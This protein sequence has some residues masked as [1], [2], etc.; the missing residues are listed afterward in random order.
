MQTKIM[1]GSKQIK[2]NSPLAYEENIKS[3]KLSI[4]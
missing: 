2:L 3:S 1:A 4:R